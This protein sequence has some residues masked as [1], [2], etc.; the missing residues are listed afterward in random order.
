MGTFFFSSKKTTFSHNFLQLNVSL[1]IEDSI[2]Q[3]TTLFGL[4]RDQV[5]LIGKWLPKFIHT[6]VWPSL[7]EQFIDPIS[8]QTLAKTYEDLGW[9]QVRLFFQKKSSFF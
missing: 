4:T 7:Q 8:Q 2:A 5:I 9:I 1:G 6:Y 3:A